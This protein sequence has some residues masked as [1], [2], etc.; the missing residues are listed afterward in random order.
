MAAIEA[1]ALV[2]AA[3]VALLAAAGGWWLRR[4]SQPNDRAQ[5]S[6][7]RSWPHTMGTVISST[8]QVSRTGD[9]RRDNPLVL[10][11]Y[12]VAGEAFQGSRVCAQNG[13]R[14]SRRTGDDRSASSTVERYSAG[15]SVVVFYDPRN[16]ANSA[17]ER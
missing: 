14:R 17:L 6:D 9:R 15:S 2:V 1:S 13:S 5:A 11:T 10:Y 12:Q 8:V 16:P 7:V 4:N 3:P